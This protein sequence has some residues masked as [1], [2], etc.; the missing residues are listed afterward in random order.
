MTEAPERIWAEQDKHILGC[1]KWRTSQDNSPWG[2]EY[3]RADLPAAVTADRETIARAICA[4][5]CAVYGEPPCYTV[6]DA[7]WPNPD[8]GDCTCHDM[9]DAVLPR[10]TTQPDPVKCEAIETYAITKGDAGFY[11]LAGT[12][13]IFISRKSVQEC[14]D[15]LPVVKRAHD[16]AMALLAALRALAEQ[17]QSDE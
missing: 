10:F 9:A 2:T 8:C 14:L 5:R 1:G 15:S 16:E 4:E 7:P 6:E 17:E 13:G 11:H 3:V 12:D